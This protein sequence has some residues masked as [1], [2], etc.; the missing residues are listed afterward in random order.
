MVYSKRY[1]Y[2]VFPGRDNI[3]AATLVRSREYENVKIELS[4]VEAGT[5]KHLKKTKVADFIINTVAQD[6]EN[7]NGKQAFRNCLITIVEARVGSSP[8]YTFWSKSA[9]VGSLLSRVVSSIVSKIEEAGQPISG[10]I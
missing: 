9:T 8:N 5:E 4:S 3:K 1:I 6:L 7:Y 2:V 10:K